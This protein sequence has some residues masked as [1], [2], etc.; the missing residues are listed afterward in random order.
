M[1][2]YCKFELNLYSLSNIYGGW[3]AGKE[4]TDKYELELKYKKNLYNKL[5]DFFQVAKA[6]SG[7]A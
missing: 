7:K 5:K 6:H 4:I 3:L 2:S 1:I